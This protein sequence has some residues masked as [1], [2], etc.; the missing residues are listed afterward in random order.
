MMR[1]MKKK[2]IHLHQPFI[3]LFPVPVVLISCFDAVTKKNNII[4]VG[5]IGV[6]CSE[7]PM[8]SCAIRPSRY[9]YNLIRDT[10]DFVINIP[11]IEM[12]DKV[13][14]IGKISGRDCDKFAEMK[15]T[16][17]PC[18]E[19]ISPMVQECPINLECK[20]RNKLDLGSHSLFVSEILICH[21]ESNIIDSD[22]DGINFDKIETFIVN[23]DEYWKTG[24]CIRK[25]YK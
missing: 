22:G 10:G 14:Q 4:T 1:N 15:L 21:V 2:E 18:K 6:A 13:D 11:S 25:I 9:S 17:A 5:W 12:L 7:P 8:I 16:P 23:G 20:V 24:R 3:G 19:V